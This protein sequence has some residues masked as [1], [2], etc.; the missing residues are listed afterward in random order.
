[1]RLYFDASVFSA[2]Y[3]E[4]TPERLHTTREFWNTLQPHELICSTLTTDELNQA[5]AQRAEQCAAL[6]R[7]FKAPPE[8]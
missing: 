2:Y 6:L 5:E 7:G 3:D 1:M 8:L 4:R